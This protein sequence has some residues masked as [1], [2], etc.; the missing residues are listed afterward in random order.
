MVTTG[1]ASQGS[2]QRAE[3]RAGGAGWPGYRDVMRG[4]QDCLLCGGCT[5]D[6]PVWKRG[7]GLE[8]DGGTLDQADGTS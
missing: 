6:E 2:S 1:F 7:A 5:V 4:F 8:R 3:R